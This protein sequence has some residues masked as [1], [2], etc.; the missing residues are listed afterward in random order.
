MRMWTLVTVLV[1]GFTIP[2]LNA[3]REE[4]RDRITI[5]GT[6]KVVAYDQDGKLAPAEVVEAKLYFWDWPLS[7]L[8]LQEW[9]RNFLLGRSRCCCRKTQ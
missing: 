1:C 5:R 9:D 8:E 7:S 3:A 2:G 6:W 4:E